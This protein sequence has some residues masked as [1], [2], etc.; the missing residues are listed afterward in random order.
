MMPVRI[1]FSSHCFPKDMDMGKILDFCEEYKFSAME[2]NVNTKN[3]DLQTVGASLLARIKGMV[4]SGEVCFTLHPSEGVNFSDALEA[5]RR[6][7]IEKVEAAIRLAS[8]LG[9]KTV[10]VH[11][12]SVNG[13]GA[14][15]TF[16]EALS[17]TIS[18]IRRCALAAKQLGVKVNVENLCHVKGTVAPDIFSFFRMCEEIGLSLIGMTLDTGHAHLVDGLEPTL[19]VIG[20]YVEHIHIDDS[21]G[22]KS[23]HL[24]LGKGEIDFYAMADYLRTY[25]GIINIELKI[26]GDD[27][28]GPILRSRE[29]VLRLLK[30]GKK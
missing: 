1:G 25:D 7:S 12:G 2:L 4:D 22:K 3:F 26:Y 13:D 11:P 21:S 29:Y 16:Q 30:R 23:D 17:Q 24:G 19:S 27:Y 28:I 8:R 15:E 9:I 14:P 10:S 5:N 6:N 18:G 20:S